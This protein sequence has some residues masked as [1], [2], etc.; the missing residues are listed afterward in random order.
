M[1][2]GFVWVGEVYFS[3]EDRLVR[4]F[5]EGIVCVGYILVWEL[6]IMVIIGVIK[7]FGSY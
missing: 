3:F 5:V 2:E 4:I 6:L 7:V 1:G